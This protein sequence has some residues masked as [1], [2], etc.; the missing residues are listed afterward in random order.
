MKAMGT[1]SDLVRTV[2]IRADACFAGKAVAFLNSFSIYISSIGAGNTGKK[3]AG[4][5]SHRHGQASAWL[6]P[7][8]P[9]DCRDQPDT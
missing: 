3:F 7:L 1:D 4:M 9:R 8:S 2:K 6:A 5:P